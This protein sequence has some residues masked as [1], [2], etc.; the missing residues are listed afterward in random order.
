MLTVLK[1]GGSSLADEQRVMAAA[2]KAAQALW[3]IDTLGGAGWLLDEM[4]IK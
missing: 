1:F 2:E 3:C 4:N